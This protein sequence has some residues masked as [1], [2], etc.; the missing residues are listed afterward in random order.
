MYKI[1]DCLAINDKFK[2]QET[3]ILTSYLAQSQDKIQ[4]GSSARNSTLIEPIYQIKI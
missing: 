4:N 1:I 2:N 3:A